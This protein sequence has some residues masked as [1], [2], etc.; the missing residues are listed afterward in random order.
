MVRYSVETYG[1]VWYCAQH[2]TG[3]V[4]YVCVHDSLTVYKHRSHSFRRHAEPRL[5]VRNQSLALYARVLNP[6]S[7]VIAILE[8]RSPS[9]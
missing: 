1:M 7:L 3:I 6:F 2:G 9:L 4:S 8:P 5:R